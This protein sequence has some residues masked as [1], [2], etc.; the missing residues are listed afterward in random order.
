[1]NQPTFDDWIEE[2]RHSGA[3]F[4]GDR[5]RAE[6][7]GDREAEF[8]ALC[9]GVGLVDFSRRTQIE[10]IGDDR[11]QFLHNLCTNDIRKLASGAGCEA[12]LCDPQGHV[13]FFVTVFASDE[14]LIVETVDG[15]S[16]ALA[17]HFDRYLIREK[18]KIIDR[19][20]EWG[21]MLIGGRRAEAWLARLLGGAPPSELFAH[22]AAEL[23][24]Q[25]VWLGRVDMTALG[26]WLIACERAALPA[27][28]RGL[29]EADATPCGDDAWQT[30]RIEAG[31][32]LMH[33]DISQRNL[34][35]EVGR[36]DR[37]INFVKGCYIG[38]ETVARIDA[39]G[40]VN[41][42]LVGMQFADG[43]APSVGMPLHSGDK[44]AG[45]VTSLAHSPRLGCWIAL[46]YARR[47]NE[48]P[49][50]KLSSDAGTVQVVALPMP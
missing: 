31:A 22:A 10:L 42:R 7:F 35:Q 16:L 3:Q 27:L 41:W 43:Q 13:L 33:I 44:L 1:M 6:S 19:G 32:P 25:R 14:S 38:Q 46:G 49:G 26:S 34:P 9:D 24:G 36:D 20:Q 37:A 2:L 18:V 30:A 4:G 15:D 47:G 12:F 50:T 5:Q 45:H 29:R 11:V 21:E 28:W 40:H 39:L 23:F 17:A 8:Q 48:S